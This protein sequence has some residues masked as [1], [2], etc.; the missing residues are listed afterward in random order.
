MAEINPTLPTVGEDNSTADPKVRTA[1]STIVATVN[2]IEE[3]N[4]A[5]DAVTDAKL[6]KPLLVGVINSGGTVAQGTG[7]TS[8]KVSTGLYEITFDAAYGA[9]PVA[10][11]GSN[12]G[13]R[14]VAEVSTTTTV[15]TVQILNLAGT[16]TDAK[17]NF[18][19]R[20]I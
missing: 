16:A 14:F 13:T 7:F 11:V 2:D 10:L 20:A 6:A 12:A 8:S 17:F 9:A 4:L 5:D 18:M 1:L 19:V 15:L 3:A